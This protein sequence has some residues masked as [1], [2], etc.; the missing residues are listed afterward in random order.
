VHH[1]PG[2]RA[3]RRGR[4]AAAGVR[5]PVPCGMHRQMAARARDVPAV[6]RCRRSRRRAGVVA[7][8]TLGQ[9]H[10]VV[11]YKA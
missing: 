1:L 6:P 11:E 8:L 10:A 3:G 9:E 4:A 2:P 7:C 5:A